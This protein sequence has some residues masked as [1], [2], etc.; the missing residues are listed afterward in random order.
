MWNGGE[1]GTL[2]R[3]LIPFSLKTKEKHNIL[4]CS[5]DVTVYCTVC[6]RAMTSH[7]KEKLRCCDVS[8][9]VNIN[10]AT[11]VQPCIPADMNSAPR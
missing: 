5:S 6:Q 7:L 2:T 4:S 3:E 1:D 11:E 8:M 9:C 10:F